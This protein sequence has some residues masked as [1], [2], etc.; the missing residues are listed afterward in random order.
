MRAQPSET[1][2]TS[3]FAAIYRSATRA[4]AEQRFDAWCD[5]LSPAVLPYFRELVHAV[6]HRR[7]D[8]FNYFDHPIT[9]AHT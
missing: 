9:N 1:R 7:H 5:P 6:R 3:A 4:E 8:A 2:R